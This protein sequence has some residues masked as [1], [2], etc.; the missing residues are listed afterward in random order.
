M[1]FIREVGRG[2]ESIL[3]GFSFSGENRIGVRF[4]GFLR[5]YLSLNGTL[6]FG[7]W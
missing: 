7:V 4:W 2:V 3:R 1:G 5:V 6:W